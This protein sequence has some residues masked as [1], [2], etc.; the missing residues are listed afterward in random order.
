M[1][2]SRQLLASAIS[3]A[4]LPMGIDMPGPT[5][6]LALTMFTVK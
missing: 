2:A 6:T 3:E 1:M 5:A 4:S